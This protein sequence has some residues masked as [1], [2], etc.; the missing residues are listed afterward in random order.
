[1]MYFNI[2]RK[3]KKKIKSGK[4]KVSKR[5]KGRSNKDKNQKKSRT[6]TGG[7]IELPTEKV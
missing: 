3:S 4:N 1:M 6:R 2:S 5:R 7:F